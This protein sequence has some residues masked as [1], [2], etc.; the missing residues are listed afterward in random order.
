MQ[1]TTRFQRFTASAQGISLFERVILLPLFRRVSLGRGGVTTRRLFFFSLL[2]GSSVR[3]ARTVAAPSPL[4][5][6]T[7]RS[8]LMNRFLAAEKEYDLAD[9][10]P[11]NPLLFRLAGPA[12][13]ADRELCGSSLFLRRPFPRQDFSAELSSRRVV[14]LLERQFSRCFGSSYWDG[15]F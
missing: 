9:H 10:S 11:T 8:F 6:I 15:V 1:G 4:S 7:N 13:F 3:D 2:P 14:Y 12:F 5:R